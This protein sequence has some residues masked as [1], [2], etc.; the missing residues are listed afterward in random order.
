MIAYQITSCSFNEERRRYLWHCIPKSHSPADSNGFDTVLANLIGLGTLMG[1]VEEKRR[2]PTVVV[3]FSVVLVKGGLVT[4]LC[5]LLR[6][7]SNAIKDKIGEC[8]LINS[9]I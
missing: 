2:T 7:I 8:N 3:G 5:Y 1:T 4:I 9:V 6:F